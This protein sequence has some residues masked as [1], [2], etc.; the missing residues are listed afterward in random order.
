MLPAG[1]GLGRSI[2]K[3]LGEALQGTIEVQ[4][5]PEAGA[6]FT[7]RIHAPRSVG[8]DTGQSDNAT[9]SSVLVVDDHP[10]NREI[11]TRILRGAGAFVVA[12]DN[13]ASGLDA[14]ASQ[15]FDL[16]L[17]DL[18]LPDMSGAAVA[19]A[20]R[21]G[22][23]PNALTRICAFTAAHVDDG[24]LPPTFN[25]LLAKPLDPRALIEM[26]RK[27]ASSSKPSDEIIR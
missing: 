17:L 26:A 9:V 7:V 21:D 5:A 18:N 8:P 12:A 13:G 15:R 22:N 24:S 25:D 20:I 19:S 6:C 3:G 4:S 27:P 1:A 23:G 14:A 11:C 16:I 2:C 10:A